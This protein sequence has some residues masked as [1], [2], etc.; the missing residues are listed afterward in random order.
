M[1][2]AFTTYL[3]WRQAYLEVVAA[4]YLFY[5][6]EWLFQITKPSFLSVLTWSESIRVLLVSP[7]Y[8]VIPLLMAQTAAVLL[9]GGL[10]RLVGRRLPSPAVFIPAAV[11]LATVLLLIN[12]FTY[13]M[14]GVGVASL[15]GVLRYV[16]AGLSVG[17][18]CLVA[19][20]RSPRLGSVDLPTRG[21]RFAFRSAVVVLALACL[22]AGWEL[23]VGNRAAAVAVDGPSDAGRLPDIFFISMDGVQADQVALY[24]YEN[25]TTPFLDEWSREAM[26]FENAFSNNCYTTGAIMGLLSGKRPTDFRL[27]Y[28]PMTLRGADAYEH[29]PAILRKLGYRSTQIAAPYWVSARHQGMRNAFDSVN[30]TDTSSQELR[31]LPVEWTDRFPSQRYFL[32]QTRDRILARLQHLWGVRD[33]VA[34]MQIVGKGT[35]RSWLG[36]IERKDAL[37]RFLEENAEGP[38]FA[39]VHFMAG[40]GWVALQEAAYRDLSLGETEIPTTISAYEDAIRKVDALLGEI[41]G[42]LERENR[43]DN[44]I[45]VVTSDH[46]RSWQSERRLPLVIRFPSGTPRGRVSANAQLS[47]VA[48]TVLDYLGIAKPAWMT[49]DS[50]LDET[51]LD[52]Q[53]PIIS[54]SE[55]KRAPSR[56]PRPPL[57]GLISA[58][59]VIC[60]RW[61]RLALADGALT[62]GPVEGH[63]AGCGAESAPAREE[64]K[65]MLVRHLTERGFGLSFE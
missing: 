4:V 47:D 42:W 57:Y 22:L 30:L 52:R 44:S 21:E 12:N 31:L 34:Y 16:F 63:T 7:L 62:S 14:F 27:F 45:I 11:H 8:L 28:P 15:T 55:V 9:H 24:G 32:V 48:P 10:N 25:V 49:G 39:Q 33:M 59:A 1:A 23:M 6:C 17:V 41:I 56:N 13:T 60:D 43:L 2:V 35:K 65:A 64:V 29:L 61:Y 53:R 36:D 50:L 40:H 26:V 54:A 38:R 19:W 20:K 5:A 51:A 37:L 46:G 18:F 58:S 3:Q